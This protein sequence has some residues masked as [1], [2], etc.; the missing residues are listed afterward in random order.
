VSVP[1]HRSAEA[2][3]A[4]R[5]HAFGRAMAEEISVTLAVYGRMFH[6][7]AGLSPADVTRLGEEVGARLASYRP[8]LLDEIVGIAAGAG[9]PE[10]WLLAVNARTELLNSGVVA[11]TPIRHVGPHECSVAGVASP[12]SPALLAQTWDFHPDLRRARVL[13]VIESP[14]IPW[15]ATFTEAG[16][17]AKTGMNAHGLALCLTF[18]AWP[19]AAGVDGVPVHVLARCVL[20]ECAT[21]T[22][23]I[24]RVE[25]AR[26][27]AA[28]C[29]AIAARAPSADGH[30]VALE[31][32]PDRA[33]RVAPD[34]LGHLAHTNHF[35][36]PC[37]PS[38][39]TR[40]SDHSRARLRQLRAALP[41]VSAD[42]EGQRSLMTLLSSSQDP[43][44]P[45]F[46]PVRTD[47]PWL[48]RSATLATLVY[49]VAQMRM[50]MRD[51]QDA[52]APFGEVALPGAAA[53]DAG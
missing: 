36:D 41:V 48:E 43:L 32:T 34:G 51:G 38:I 5:G 25:A 13:W 29:L 53:A 1:C 22:D 18:L 21:V 7:D 49:D 16:L 45:I 3:P 27:S 39:A 31:L 47:V 52:D 20:E 44:H 12:A 2:S 4:E 33:F 28:V 8:A 14:E 37:A 15:L 17:V 35:L 46:R 11:G 42:A 24:G 6:E 50:W 10:A 26:R 40:G 23:A 30:L 9:Q 19:E